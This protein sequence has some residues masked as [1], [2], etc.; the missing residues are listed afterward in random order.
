MSRN[1]LATEQKE[2][3]HPIKKSR[4]AKSRHR[5]N[6]L[7]TWFKNLATGVLAVSLGLGLSLSLGPFACSGLRP[8]FPCHV[9]AETTC[10]PPAWSDFEEVREALR[11]ALEAAYGFRITSDVL[12]VPVSVST[13]TGYGGFYDAS[14]PVI[15]LSEALNTRT[16]S[17]VHEVLQHRLPHVLYGDAYACND[18][19]GDGL[20]CEPEDHRPSWQPTVERLL[21]LEM[22]CLMGGN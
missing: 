14:G 7:V 18:L 12:D 15:Y 2:S 21:M 9:A 19:D 17:Y 16:S 3:P 10:H 6:N 11:C 20:D 1:N 22:E 8:L 5:P 13:F 4:H